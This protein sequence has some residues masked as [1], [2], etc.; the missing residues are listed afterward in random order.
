MLLL[1]GGLGVARFRRRGRILVLAALWI[2]FAFLGLFTLV[3]PYDALAETRSVPVRIGVAVTCMLNAAFWGFLLW[4]P[5][6]FF[7]SERVRSLCSEQATVAAE[8]RF[9]NRHIGVEAAQ[10]E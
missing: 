4:L 9:K 5:F 7:A 2:A 3:L 8:P 6:R 10:S 1:T